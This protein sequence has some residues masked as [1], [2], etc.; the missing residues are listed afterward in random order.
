MVSCSPWCRL[1]PVSYKFFPQTWNWSQSRLK[2]KSNSWR[3]S[4]V[5]EE[6]DPNCSETQWEYWVQ[7]RGITVMM[8]SAVLVE[9]KIT[10]YSL[11]VQFWI[12]R[13]LFI[14]TIKMVHVCLQWSTPGCVDDSRIQT[15]T[16]CEFVVLLWWKTTNWTKETPSTAKN[17]LTCF[18]V[19]WVHSCWREEP[20]VPMEHGHR[21]DSAST[22]LT[23][24]SSGWKQSNLEQF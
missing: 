24:Q 18:H 7:H 4:R 11:K 20:E 5:L 12:F 8:V 19:N 3:I 14:Q 21:V 9:E 10:L 17:K 13:L 15:Q 23:Q 1:R 22:H 2:R 16:G 6:L